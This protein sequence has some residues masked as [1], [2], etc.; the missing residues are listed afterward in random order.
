MLQ[1]IAQRL[2]L[3]IPTFVGITF[4]AYAIMLLAPG[5]PVDLFFAGGL[6]AGT[7]G[8][9]SDRLAE[10]RAD[11][12]ELRRELGLDRAIPVQYALWLRR[13]LQGELGT[14]FK[15]RQPVWDK[16]RARL[17]VTIIINVAAIVLTYLIAIP[18]GIYSAVR[19]GSRF[20]Q[21]STLT[22]F[23]LY[24]LP[25]FWIGTLI[26]IFFGGGDFFAWFPPGGLRSLDWEP[27]WPWWQKLSDYAYHLAMPLLCTTYGAFA[28]LS[29]F[30]RTSM[31]EN[32]RQDYIRT[33]R[34]KG[35]SEP[36]V[37][38]KHM[39]RNSLIPVITILAGLLP[40][41]I[42]GSV[43]IETIFSI[44]GIGQLG[45]Q[46]VLAR[47]Y[48]VVIALFAASSFLTLIGILFSDI[49]LAWVD[50]RIHF[51]KGRA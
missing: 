10:V 20:D 19:S 28:A 44:P 5:D 17:P 45:Y 51:G 47:D 31:L 18:L 7:E 22:V 6:G 21:L 15:D 12:D 25:V 34:A 26:I 23:M 13:L 4:L 24:S 8:I 48:P 1:Y 42:G 29:R 41:L 39:L 36:M 27:S 14:S 40:A 37:I 38:L 3:L 33:A 50:P 9:D 30:M 2:L 49:A 11:K 43:I 35:V 32:A 16:I 46:S